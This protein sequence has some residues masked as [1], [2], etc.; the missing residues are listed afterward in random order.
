MLRS[1]PFYSFLATCF[2]QHSQVITYSK[3]LHLKCVIHSTL[4]SVCFLKLKTRMDIIPDFK[5]KRRVLHYIFTPEYRFFGGGL[6]VEFFRGSKVKFQV[7]KCSR[8]LCESCSPMYVPIS[9]IHNYK[10]PSPL[11]AG[12]KIIQS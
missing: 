2:L 6:Y 9:N 12:E 5:T 7:L 10:V 4:A 3:L 8:V 1:I 11:S